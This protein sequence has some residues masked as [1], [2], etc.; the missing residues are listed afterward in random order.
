MA[1]DWSDR[2][3]ADPLSDAFAAS[4]LIGPA[5]PVNNLGVRVLAGFLIHCK[6]FEGA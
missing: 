2:L 3:T 6:R 4:F 5:L 1:A